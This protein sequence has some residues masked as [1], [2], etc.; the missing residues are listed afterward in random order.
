MINF[1]SNAILY[2][3]LGFT[4]LKVYW[5]FLIKPQPDNFE[6]LLIESLTTG[7]VLK[8]IYD[9]PDININIY[10]DTIIMLIISALMAYGLAYFI[11]HSNYL[12][13]RLKNIGLHQNANNYIWN[14]II[15]KKAIFAQLTDY[16]NNITYYGMILSIEANNKHPQIILS[17]YKQFL[18]N[19]LIS[20]YEKKPEQLVIL[21]TSQY[22]DIQ[23]VLDPSEDILKP[24]T[25]KNEGKAINNKRNYSCRTNKKKK[26]SSKKKK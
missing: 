16:D 3:A 12:A 5:L 9:I 6:V 11:N 22:K 15:G 26:R 24:H 25:N 10:I 18:N 21:D 4:F 20:D 17:G 7:F 13:H 1:L 14:D 23:I 8:R 19:E 2:I